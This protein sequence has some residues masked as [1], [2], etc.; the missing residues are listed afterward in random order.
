MRLV[1]TNEANKAIEKICNDYGVA[2]GNNYGGFADKI[3]S[4]IDNI[5]TVDAE[6]VTH[7]HWILE[8]QPNG[9]PYCYHCSNCDSDFH[10]VGITTAFDNCPNCRA[11]MDE[12]GVDN[13]KI[14]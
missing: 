1:D 13:V 12:E 8:K 2:Y 6:P 5:P 11:K 9:K 7:A 4:V 10:Y 14:D 3:A